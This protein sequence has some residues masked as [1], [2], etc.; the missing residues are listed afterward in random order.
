MFNYVSRLF[1][2]LF[3]CVYVDMCNKTVHVLHIE[4]PVEVAADL[5]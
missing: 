5:L 4:K 2:S 3:G 1:I